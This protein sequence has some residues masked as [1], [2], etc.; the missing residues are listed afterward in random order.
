MPRAPSGS[1]FS[2]N[3]EDSQHGMVK[4][5]VVVIDDRQKYANPKGCPTAD[6]IVAQDFIEAYSSR[7]FP[8][9]ELVVIVTR[10]HFHDADILRPFM[11]P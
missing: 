5:S 9:N 2:V 1:N 11:P 8:G 6:E 7:S 3:C 10:G 4:F